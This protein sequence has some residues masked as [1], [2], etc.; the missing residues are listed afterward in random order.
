MVQ[1]VRCSYCSKYG[2]LIK[3][4]RSRIYREKQKGASER[5]TTP[6]YTSG[7]PPKTNMGP[8]RRPF[9]RKFEGSQPSRSLRSTKLMGDNDIKDEGDL[10]S[11]D[12]KGTENSVFDRLNKR[13][14]S[15][16]DLMFL[17]DSGATHHAVLDRKYLIPS[18]IRT[19]PKRA[20]FGSSSKFA[21][22]LI[23]ECTGDMILV[24]PNKREFY[25]KEVY[26]CETLRQNLFSSWPVTVDGWRII[27]DQM[28]PGVYD[29]ET[30]KR[31]IEF[32]PINRG[33]IVDGRAKTFDLSPRML[34][35]L[36]VGKSTCASTS[37]LWHQ[38][39]GHP[40]PDVQ[41]LLAEMSQVN[42]HLYYIINWATQARETIEHKPV[43][44]YNKDMPPCFCIKK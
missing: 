17:S 29:V 4:C 34:R 12:E 40:Y 25:I 6:N 8:E 11:E 7:Y 20:S 33:W 18:T 9:K 2:H 10:A 26:Y 32:I 27:H 14:H 35:A 31:I 42:N 36:T 39:F 22:D 28:A 3:D 15:P 16:Y 19:L 30:D 41:N 37:K 24:L 43:L 38:R 44:A 21:K 5:Q 13:D 1:G 23:S